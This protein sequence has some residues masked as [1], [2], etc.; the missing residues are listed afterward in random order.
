MRYQRVLDFWFEENADKW[1]IKDDSFDKAVQ[2]EFEPL[3]NEFKDL[4]HREL[5]SSPKEAL[6]MI[7]TLD[8]FPRNMYRGTPEAFAADKM[9]LCI[10]KESI[11][12]GY[13]KKLNPVERVFMYLPFE[14]SEDIEDQKDAVK[15]FTVLF[16]ENPTFA[17]VL[18]YAIQ[19]LN[20]IKRF[21]RFPHRNKILGREST[22]EEVEFLK[23]EGSSF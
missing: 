19:H 6:A 16:E 7:I 5:T 23:E 13:D 2:S 1:F 20:I 11:Q 4:P 15:F 8:Q 10:A 22:P 21:G 9:A 12:K 18:D 17:E 14:H 3:Y